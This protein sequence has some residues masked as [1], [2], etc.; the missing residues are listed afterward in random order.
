MNTPGE[1]QAGPGGEGGLGLLSAAAGKPKT[2]RPGA[3]LRR[4]RQI[5]FWEL[6]FWVLG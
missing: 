1:K 3:R 5:G 2:P 4:I 6:G